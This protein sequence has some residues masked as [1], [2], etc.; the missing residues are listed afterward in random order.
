M[1]K[2]NYEKLPIE[3]KESFRWLESIES[4]QAKVNQ[5]TK[6]IVIA[7]RGADIYEIFAQKREPNFELLIR[8]CHNR[9][10][11]ELISII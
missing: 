9:K 3:E 1:V 8:A 7:D 4:A 6:A 5:K 2:E 10:S 11:M